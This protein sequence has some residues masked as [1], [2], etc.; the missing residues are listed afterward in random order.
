M[1]QRRD[2]PATMAIPYTTA[3]LYTLDKANK[4]GSTVP[5]KIQ[6]NDADEA[7]LSDASLSVGRSA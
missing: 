3:P 5:I 2:Q 4:A 1:P 7:N 6:V